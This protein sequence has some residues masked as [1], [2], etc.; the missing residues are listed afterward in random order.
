MKKIFSLLV[1]LIWLASSVFAQDNAAVRVVTGQTENSYSSISEAVAAVNNSNAIS[2]IQLLKSIDLGDKN[3]SLSHTASLDFNGY[4]I[5]GW[6][7]NILTITG[8]DTQVTLLDSSAKGEG[9]IRCNL[10]ECDEKPSSLISLQGASL[11][12]QSGVIYAGNSYSDETAPVLEITDHSTF[13]MTGGNLQSWLK[14][15]SPV[16]LAKG[17][18]TCLNIGG[19]NITS[20][21]MN[22]GVSAALSIEDCC[23]S[24]TGGEIS[25]SAAYAY[26]IVQSRGQLNIKD[27]VITVS[28]TSNWNSNATAVYVSGTNV[29]I[30][31]GLFKP[32]GSMHSFSFIFSNGTDAKIID[33]KFLSTSNNNKANDFSVDASSHL[34]ISGGYFSTYYKDMQKY[35][36]GKYIAAFLPKHALYKEGYRFYISDTEVSM[37]EAVNLTRSIVYD[38]LFDAIADA[39]FGDVV[40]ISKDYTLT[41]NLIIPFGVALLIPYNTSNDCYHLSPCGSS[42]DYS[43]DD[44]AVENRTFTIA[45]GITLTVNGALNVG[46][47]QLAGNGGNTDGAGAVFGYYGAVN[48]GTGSE[49]VVNGS[50]YCWGYIYGK[51]K[52]TANSGSTVHESLVF[53]DWHGGTISSAVCDYIF[54]MNQMYVQ[55]IEVPI[56]FKYNAE[57]LVTTGLSAGDGILNPDPMKWIYKRDG[58]FN[59]QEGASLTRT[60]NPVTDRVTY[61]ITGNVSLGYVDMS[62]YGFSINSKECS[63]GLNNNWDIKVSKGTLSMPYNYRMLPGCTLTIDENA[64]LNIE[65]G[66]KLSVLGKKN[67]GLYSIGYLM[68]LKYTHA[69]GY[70]NR[71]IRAVGDANNQETLDKMTDAALNINGR[72]NVNGQLHTNEGAKIVSSNGTGTIRFYE[73]AVDTSAYLL[74]IVAITDELQKLYLDP[75]ALTN[76][77]G[78]HILTKDAMAGTMFAMRQNAW[79]KFAFAVNANEAGLSTY[80][81]TIDVAVPT[82]VQAFKAVAISCDKIVL[83]ELNGYIPAGTGVILRYGEGMNRVEF[84]APITGAEAA[85]VTGN[86]LQATTTAAKAIVDRPSGTIFALGSQNAFQRYEGNLIA[87]RA[88][89]VVD[90]TAGAKVQILFDD[91]ATFINTVSGSSGD[92]KYMENGR[93]VIQ[94]NGRKYNVVGQFIK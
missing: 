37:G 22:G 29:S 70:N 35:V 18:N 65:K 52:V 26:A 11:T 46:A 10:D 76:A 64:T 43:D 57:E 82:G 90:G 5:S 61:T 92:G 86:L 49:I 88:F 13:N 89:L 59:L 14:S 40:S 60:Y 63:L 75:A 44:L 53:L 79:E 56:T 3:I 80:S 67:Y 94:R 34:K 66:H 84:E 24:I 16:V 30:E 47:H 21:S 74:N 17:S 31:G 78:S 72:L 69:N 81:S 2:T 45:D 12:L 20:E 83:T 27:G 42:F 62:L 28:A 25:A 32:V 1:G 36:D 33:G 41:Q 50:L 19:G 85:D 4:T 68:P 71:S 87:N 7:T 15:G 8:S 58:L 48:M 73:N 6:G 39:K 77:D 54:P 38:S 9:G 55:N 23:C 91:D 51:G 93:L